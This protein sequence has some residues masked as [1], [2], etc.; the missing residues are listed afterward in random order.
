M[1]RPVVHWELMSKDTAKVLAFYEKIFGWKIRHVP[2]LN[3]RMV[4]TGSKS[5]CSDPVPCACASTMI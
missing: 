4:E 2:E 3:Y 5:S 1:G